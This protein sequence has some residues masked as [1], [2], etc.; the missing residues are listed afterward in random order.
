MP[1]LDA[2]HPQWFDWRWQLQNNLDGPQL[3]DLFG[4]AHVL[5]QPDG[6]EVGVTPWFAQLCRES[7]GAGPLARQ[8]VPSAAEYSHAAFE[9]DDPLGEDPHRVAP[10]LVRKYPDR[11]LL[12]VTDTCASYCRYCTRSRWVAS[13][14]EPLG[15][16]ALDEAITWIEDHPAIADVLISGGDPLLLSTRRLSNLLD[17]LAAIPHLRFIR[18]GTRVPVFLPMRID[19]DL[20]TALRPRRIPVYVNVHINHFAELPEY[21]RSK[22]AMLA[23]AGVP[24][25]GQAVLLKGVNNDVDTLRETFYRMLTCRVRPYYLFHCD[26]VKGT[27][28]LRTSVDEGLELMRELVGHVSGMA[29]PKYCIDLEGG[30]KVPLWPEYVEKKTPESLWVRGYAGQVQAYPNEVQ[31]R[32]AQD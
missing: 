17:R 16:D 5:A 11:V 7:G 28:H 4:T 19:A 6:F 14:Q 18:I 25:G 21:T 2:E 3:A 1:Q 15:R 13:H 20:A 24:L 12:L 23:D 8:V 26:P 9:R 29:V 31:S 27:S 22:L 32:D 30:G 10:G